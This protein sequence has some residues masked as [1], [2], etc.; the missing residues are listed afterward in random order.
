[1]NCIETHDFIHRQAT[2]LLEAFIDG[3]RKDLNDGLLAMEPKIAFAVVAVMCN[4]SNDVL[5]RSLMS[6]LVESA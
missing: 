3:N 5:M 4:S 6:Y 2:A 1:M